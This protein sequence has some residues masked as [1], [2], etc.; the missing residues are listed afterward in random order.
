MFYILT[1]TVSAL[2]I[3]LGNTLL[4]ETV[5][6]LAFWGLLLYTVLSIIGVFAIDGLSAFVI[7]R[8]PERWFAPEASAFSVPK[9][10][11]NLYRRTGIA[12]WKKHVPEWG[13]F[14]GFHKDHLREP[15]DS[16]YLGRFLLES[17][18]G[19]AGHVAGALLGFL[20]LLVPIFGPL[21]VS[22]P[23][24]AINAILSLLPTMVLRYNTPALR[25]LYRRTRDRELRAQEK[26]R[27]DVSHAASR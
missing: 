2:L 1:I 15:N 3:A 5:F 4:R 10:E 16:A 6:P 12:R 18:Y 9:W 14:T 23:V 17:N 25:S 20:I 27:A 8:L 19:V 22:I 7:R 11:K 21:S 13:C 24:A 26:E